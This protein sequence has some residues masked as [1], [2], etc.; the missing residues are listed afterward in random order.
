MD[1]I[2]LAN[3]TSPLF[4][5]LEM[6]SNYDVFKYSMSKSYGA[7]SKQKVEVPIKNALPNTISTINLPR[8]GLTHCIYLRLAFKIKTECRFPNTGWFC[9]L[10][11]KATL[12]THSREIETL[13]SNQILQYVLEQSTTDNN[14]MMKRLTF[15]E[16]TSVLT[17]DRY[18]I[19]Y[20]PLPFSF[21]G[22]SSLGYKSAKDMSFLEKCSVSLEW[23]DWD[24]L[25]TTPGPTY[26]PVND[27]IK[28]VVQNKLKEADGTAPL[29]NSGAHQPI[30][31]SCLMMNFI[32]VPNEA[33]RMLQRD[34]YRI[35][36]GKPLSVIM[37]NTVQEIDR[38]DENVVATSDLNKPR[39]IKIDLTSKHVIY[40][41]RIILKV[42]GE[43]KPIVSLRLWMSGRI[44]REW[45]DTSEIEFENALEHRFGGASR[46][47]NGVVAGDN[48]FVINHNI[49][50]DP[51]N[52]C[53]GALSLKGVSSPQLEVVFCPNTEGQYITYVEH[54]YYQLCSIQGSDGQV[55]IA[56]S[57]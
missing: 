48:V 28:L 1:E 55:H 41:T 29:L 12:S 26:G 45:N 3:S 4:N 43:R 5:S 21:F 18:I 19:G 37:S 13:S 46:Q 15:F 17:Q 20:I 33:R 52:K 25:A 47:S 22:S 16:N 42:G 53:S 10:I 6:N 14:S 56:L 2:L 54:S 11:R 38:W 49:D 31:N 57:Q 50:N 27:A 36:N 32:N 44:V 23:N 7:L 39:S 40:Q 35:K 34:T 51:L 24:S 8:Y 9:N 30:Y